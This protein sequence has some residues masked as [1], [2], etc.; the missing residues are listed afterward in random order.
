M[1]KSCLEIPN[2]FFFVEGLL[3]AKYIC[4]EYVESVCL[5]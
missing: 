1:R 4:I 2:S 3:F 5:C